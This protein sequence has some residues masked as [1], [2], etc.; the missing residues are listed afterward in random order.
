M[1]GIEIR[2]AMMMVR[3]HRTRRGPKLVEL[4][5][6]TGSNIVT[7]ITTSTKSRESRIIPV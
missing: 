4:E 7:K 6:R 1:K 3:H 5:R 2:V